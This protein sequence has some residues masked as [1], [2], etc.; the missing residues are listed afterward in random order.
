M[1]FIL[2]YFDEKGNQ[3]WEEILG[4]DVMQIRVGELIEELDCDADDIMV[5]DKDTQW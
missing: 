4:E 3:C 5:F 1:E 2:C